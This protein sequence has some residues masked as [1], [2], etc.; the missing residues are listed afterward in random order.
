MALTKEQKE[1]FQALQVAHRLQGID[2]FVIIVTTRNRTV[3]HLIASW[4]V[5]LEKQK[6]GVIY[7]ENTIYGIRSCMV[8]MLQG[9]DGL[10]KDLPNY[11]DRLAAKRQAKNWRLQMF[12]QI[13][14]GTH[15]NVARSN[16]R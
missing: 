9:M 15:L 1:K 3:L 13:P 8:T 16:N 12:K 7:F 10:S 14:E 11:D 6:F 2:C 4:I 5:E